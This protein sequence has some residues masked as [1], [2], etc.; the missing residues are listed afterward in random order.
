MGDFLMGGTTPTTTT[1]VNNLT[2]GQ[3]N[4]LSYLTKNAR[5]GGVNS[6]G[7][8]YT[9][10]ASGLQQ[11]AFSS[12][13]D[14]L[15][16]GQGMGQAQ[17]F[18]TSLM[19]PYDD[20][21]A[22]TYYQDAILAPTMQNWQ[23]EV[24]PQVREAMI[25]QGAGSSGAA[26]RAIAKSGADMMTNLNANMASTLYGDKQRYTQNAMGGA[27]GLSQV[28]QLLAQLGLSGGQQQRQI[29]SEQGQEGYND[30]LMEQDWN[31]PWLQYSQT[32]LGT[33]AFDNVVQQGSTQ[34]G[35]LG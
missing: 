25:S 20:T 5:G 19:Q 27:Q 30:W 1:K 35:A 12:I 8:T 23:N 4:L 16:G 17:D 9:P 11:G 21:A 13:E 32:A 6:Y 33:R 26:N 15:A 7:G 14:M 22:K 10:G 28:N 24:L 29:A 34:Q 31:N 2:G 3:K 18:L